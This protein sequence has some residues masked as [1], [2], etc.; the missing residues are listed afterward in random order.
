MPQLRP[1]RSPDSM[2]VHPQFDSPRGWPNRPYAWHADDEYFQ[3][4]VQA[5]C[6]QYTDKEWDDWYAIQDAEYDQ[7]D[8]DDDAWGE[9]NAEDDA[10]N[11]EPDADPE[12]DLNQSS[13]EPGPKRQRQC[14]T[15]LRLDH[16]FQAYASVSDDSYNYGYGHELDAHGN[17]LAPTAVSMTKTLPLIHNIYCLLYTSPSPRD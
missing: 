2:D 4:E 8:D 5:L 13:S 10:A 6:H 3:E 17:K 16:M 11:Q 14:P 15:V 7:D 12:P 9:W 1:P